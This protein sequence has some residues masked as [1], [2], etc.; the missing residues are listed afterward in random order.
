MF[1]LSG[2]DSNDGMMKI[3]RTYTGRSKIISFVGAYHGSTYG[4]ISLSALSL[5]MRR[6]I[7]PL[8]PDIH[9]INYP[10]CCRCKCGKKA[11]TWS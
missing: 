10:D 3:A 5:N 9:H 2:S 11:E 8:V 4:S 7:G 1:G 6:R